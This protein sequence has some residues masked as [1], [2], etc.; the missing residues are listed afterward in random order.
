MLACVKEEDSTTR[1][2]QYKS[3]GQGYSKILIFKQKGKV[4][5]EFFII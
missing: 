4:D 3:R 2:F 1:W 5:E